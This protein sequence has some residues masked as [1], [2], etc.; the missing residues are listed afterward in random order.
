MSK[1][2]SNQMDFETL[3]IKTIVDTYPVLNNNLI[4]TK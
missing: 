1:L 4:V 3:T 2:V